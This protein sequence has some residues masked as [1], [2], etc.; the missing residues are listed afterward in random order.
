MNFGEK[1]DQ[2]VKSKI[3]GLIDQEL[4]QQF[5]SQ[6]NRTKLSKDKILDQIIKDL[7]QVGS[8]HQETGFGKSKL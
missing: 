4:G 6:I 2:Q 5:E 3:S 1:V 7:L 8:T